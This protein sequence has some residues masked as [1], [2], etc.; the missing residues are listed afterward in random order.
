MKLYFGVE[1]ENQTPENQL[2]WGLVFRRGDHVLLV[3][4]FGLKHQCYTSRALRLLLCAS[5]FFAWSV[6]PQSYCI[7]HIYVI[8]YVRNIAE[9][10]VAVKDISISMHPLAP[11]ISN[12]RPKPDHASNQKEV[13]RPSLTSMRWKSF[14]LSRCFKSFRHTHD[15]KIEFSQTSQNVFP[16]SKYSLTHWAQREWEDV[17]LHISFRQQVAFTS[18]RGCNPRPPSSVFVATT[19]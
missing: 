12:K 4:N 14:A 1:K 16:L 15:P 7:D 18:F 9:S 13:I 17:T 6:P 3:L 2:T 19:S 8:E 10:T 5:Y 11:T